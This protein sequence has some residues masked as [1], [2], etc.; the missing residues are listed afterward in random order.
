VPNERLPLETESWSH[1][2]T[3]AQYGETTFK[4]LFAPRQL[5]GHGT[6]VEVF[7][8]LLD[9]EKAKGTVGEATK[10]ASVYLGLS[11]DKLRD[12]NS[13]MTGW[14]VNREVMVNTFDRHDF[15]FSYFRRPDE[16]GSRPTFT[17]SPSAISYVTSGVLMKK[18]S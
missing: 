18:Q 17:P 14:H 10:A 13:R 3:P 9:E 7:R 8:E 16:K 12:Y 6:S 5:L 15:S 4:V 2:N 11:L 1:G